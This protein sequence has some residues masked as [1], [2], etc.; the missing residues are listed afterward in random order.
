MWRTTISLVVLTSVPAFSQTHSAWEFVGPPGFSDGASLC[1]RIAADPAGVMHVAFQDLSQ[2]SAR[3]TVMKNTGDAWELVGVKGGA[4]VGTAYYCNVAFDAAG[5]VVVATRDYGVNS[6]ANVRRFDSSSNAWTSVGAPGIGTGEAHYVS[7]V[8]STGG[9]PCIVYADGALGNRATAQHF[10]SSSGTWVPIGTAGF[11]Q[12]GASFQSITRAPD[13]TL[14]AAYADGAFLDATNNVGRATVVRFDANSGTWMPVGTPGFSPHGAANLVLTIDRVGLPWIAYYR[15]HNSVVVMRYDG[16]SWNS[17]GG[18]ATGVDQ[19]TVD[20][21]DWR[22]WLSLQFD[23]ANRPYVAYQMNTNGRRASVRRFDNDAW[24]LVGDGSFT[25]GAADYMTMVLDA[26]DTPW[27]AFRD[28]AHAQRVSV[29]RYTVQSESFCTAVTSS[30]GCVPQIESVGAPSLTG[31][32]PFTIRATNIITD[33]PGMLI[34][35]FASAAVPFQG[36]TLCIGGAVRRGG[37]V[38]SGPGTGVPDCSGVFT[39]NFGAA[40]AS[41]LPGVWVGTELSAQFWYRDSQNPLGPGLT[42]GLRFVVGP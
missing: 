40:L 18:S 3:A 27:V 37:P 1:T 31:S 29:M 33:R 26:Q 17:I 4:S 25:P 41:G 30:L 36:G 19:P 22:Q 12:L 23:S 5:R 39:S 11:S 9:D 13:G 6:K 32:T 34:Y 15:Y 35:G 21:E 20:T 14:Y 7:L 38:N 16:T 8:C 2:T 24:Q 10:D 28:G 42:N